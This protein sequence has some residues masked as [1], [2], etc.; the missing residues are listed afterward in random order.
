[1]TDT[2]VAA[3]APAAAPQA[4]ET[5]INTTPQSSPN[6]ISN[7]PP[8]AGPIVEGSPHRPPSRREAIQ[9]AF[10]R[11]TKQQDEGTARAAKAAP[12]DKD[13]KPADAKVGHNKPPEA[14]DSEKPKL[15]LKKRPDEQDKG[16]LE[17]PPG[18]PRDR[19]R[20][21]PKNL[22]EVGATSEGLGDAA[23]KGRIE[24]PVKPAAHTLPENA[25]YREAPPR[26]SEAAKAD[27]ASTPESVRGDIHRVQQEF[28]KAY[29]QLKPMADAYQPVARFDQMARQ[30]G[31]TL[32]KALTNYVGM[33]QKLRS[34]VI[35][36][37][38]VIINNLG[39]KAQD[40]SP[41]GLR[42]IAYHVLSQ[43][44]EQLAQL[45]QGNVQKAAGQQIGALH[46]EIAGLK[47]A[48]HQMHSAQQFTYTQA[49]VNQFADSHPRFD[50]LIPLIE[51]E[52][53]LGF[54]L[55]TAY[56]R[57]ELLNPASTAPQTRATAA[58]TR[59]PADKSI[60]G[61]PGAA[62]TA[63]PRRASEKPTGRREAIANAI[64]RVNGGF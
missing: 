31:T 42:D 9:A 43:S 7:T 33:E 25:P 49:Q 11:A 45:Q 23:A 51:R 40:G 58:Q 36:G 16:T 32:E 21:A 18:Q 35:G 10:D 37:L 38:D 15:N 24:P 13:A 64:K 57:A 46:Q 59:A 60:S 29:S 54:D 48:L 2:T 41:I 62:V 27:W 52:L 63:A 28:G 19:G 44:P 1:M 50:E 22:S 8:D 26:M 14:V 5:P 3:P 20:F 53:Q 56:R 4:T 30:H 6:P 17:T 61:S 39:L 47:N 34:D 12:A 55:E